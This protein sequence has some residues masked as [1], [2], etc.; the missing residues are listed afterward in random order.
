[1]SLND[2]STSPVKDA[3]DFDNLPEQMGAYGP[4]LQPGPYR[5]KLSK[6]GVDNFD[7]IDHA[8][9]GER[10]KVKFD[11][12]AP[13]IVVQAIDPAAVGETFTTQIS[14]VGRKRG[15]KDDENAPVVSDMDY[16]LKAL[17]VTARPKSNRELGDTLIAKSNGAAEFGADLEWSV[18]CNP[19][20]EAKW[21][22]GAGGLTIQ[23]DEAGT[24]MKGCGTRVYQKDI[25]KLDG[26]FVERMTCPGCAASLR[27]FGNLTRF[28]PAT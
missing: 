27:A 2:L 1:M 26:K 5:W 11:Q 4:L 13:L 19:N 10:L 25:A 3:V 15:K 7:K 16:L 12:S 22:D 21:D 6:L 24:P 17:G 28:K 18:S 20:R 14:N 23:N 9:Q 8:E